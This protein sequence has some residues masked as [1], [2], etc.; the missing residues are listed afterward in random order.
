MGVDGY[1][2]LKAKILRI[3]ICRK[4]GER[5]DK[6]F[7]KRKQG[8]ICKEC[9]MGIEN[10]CVH[11]WVIDS[12]NYGVCKKCHAGKQFPIPKKTKFLTYPILGEGR[13][14]HW[15]VFSGEDN[16]PSQDNAIR[17][18]EDSR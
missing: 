3:R 7:K 15:G 5:L 14:R 17:I 4:C 9:L 18:L 13:Q 8:Y 2:K 11:H 16:N 10:I 6:D 12:A 1:W